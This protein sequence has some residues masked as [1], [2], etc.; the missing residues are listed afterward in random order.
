MGSS[1]LELC[2]LRYFRVHV[3]VPER[4]LLDTLDVGVTIGGRR[5]TSDERREV[6][7]NGEGGIVEQSLVRLVGSE[8]GRLCTSLFVRGL[9]FISIPSI[10]VV[11]LVSWYYF[12]FHYSSS[13]DVSVLQSPP[14]RAKTLVTL[15]IFVSD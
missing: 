15:V 14:S 1:R 3:P 6:L 8:G 4:N 10:Y 9:R 5:S 12:I 11:S 2:W 7:C 13:G